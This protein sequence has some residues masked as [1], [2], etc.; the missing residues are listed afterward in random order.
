MHEIMHL[1]L[2]KNHS[3]DP[4]SWCSKFRIET[5]Q[6]STFPEKSG[7]FCTFVKKYCWITIIWF[8][9]FTGLFTKKAII[10]LCFQ[11]KFLLANFVPSYP[12]Q[13]ATLWYL[14]ILIF[15][16]YEGN[17]K[18]LF[19]DTCSQFTEWC[20]VQCYW[21]AQTALLFCCNEVGKSVL[22]FC[23]TISKIWG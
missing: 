18:P 3:C 16:C 10:K 15:W 2:V 5:N 11:S 23:L 14:N 1:L 4:F 19:H 21:M 13:G 22:L 8:F 12:V 6:I 9:N 20:L 17:Q 7:T